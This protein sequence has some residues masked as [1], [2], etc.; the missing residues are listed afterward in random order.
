[1]LGSAL[2]GLVRLLGGG[3]GTE[4][5]TV[6]PVAE[7]TVTGA[8][9]NAA[10]ALRDSLIRGAVHAGYACMRGMCTH[11]VDAAYASVCV[12]GFLLCACG[13]DW[14]SVAVLACLSLISIVSARGGL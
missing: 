13:A 1:M 2:E 9:D 10:H 6:M 4:V 8:N 7:K 14:S 12:S 3:L 11:R 5:C